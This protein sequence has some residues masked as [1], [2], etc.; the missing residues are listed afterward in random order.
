M[1]C[2]LRTS[3]QN[4][5][6]SATHESVFKMINEGIRAAS[7]ESKLKTPDQVQK[8]ITYYEKASKSNCLHGLQSVQVIR[9]VRTWVS[10]WTIVTRVLLGFCQGVI[11]F[12]FASFQLLCASLQLFFDS[13]LGVRPSRPLSSST[14]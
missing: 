4:Q 10:R 7:D 13:V 2:R 14:L 6:K 11:F 1:G 9:G 5:K 12:Y 8:L 3:L